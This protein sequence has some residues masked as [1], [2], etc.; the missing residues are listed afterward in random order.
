MSEWD[1]NLFQDQK[2]ERQSVN[3]G[4]WDVLLTV[5]T[6][7]ATAAAAFLMAYLTKDIAT[8]PF[9]LLGLC[10]AVPVAALMFSAWCKEKIFPSM[11]PNTSRK[12]QL[13]L[14]L[15]SILAAAVVGCFSQFSNKEAA[16]AVV[17]EGWSNALI[18]LDKSG[19]MNDGVKNENATSAVIRLVE[20]MNEDTRVGLLIDVDWERK[21]FDDHMIPIAPLTNDHRAEI[22]SMAGYFSDGVAEFKSSL[23]KA[24][25]MISNEEDPST[26]T[27]LY[28]SDGVDY[29]DDDVNMALNAKDFYE[30][31]NL[32]G[33]KINYIYVDANH[34]NELEKLAELTSG[35]SIYAV[36]A[37]EITDKMQ[38]IATVTTLV[39]KDALRDI[40]DSTLAK[41]VTAVL[42]LLLGILI[43]FSLTIMFSLQGQKRAQLII[44][45]LMALSAFLLLAFGKDIIPTAWIREGIAFSLL[46]VV[47]MRCNL[48]GTARHKSV[49]T[50]ANKSTPSSATSSGSDSSDDLW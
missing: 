20:K 19:S 31:F 22:V 28:L 38:Q 49:S 11:T 33:V 2:K 7:G 44:S 37:D 35:T 45:P 17:Q 23:E 46:G 21:E 41:I 3:N 10:F 40:N 34:S 24:Y 5:I 15:C 42:L 9:W 36:H 18:I 27:I 6:L 16:E 12:A 39:Y 13:I 8:R 30:R 25:E 48:V 47:I 14:V 43:G 50:S 26:F 32:L 29:Y 4:P 1:D